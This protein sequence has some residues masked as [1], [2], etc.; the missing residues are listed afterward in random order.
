MRQNYGVVVVA[1]LVL[2]VVPVVV[3]GAPVVVVVEVE[4]AV[5]SGVAVVVLVVVVVEVSEE[6]PH[7]ANE[8]T[9][10]K[11]AAA[12]AMVW[13]FEVI[14]SDRLLLCLMRLFVV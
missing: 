8:A 3:A 1:V 6:P 5:A 12:R 11:L 9:S 14:K 7:A 2:V 10:A 4:V 13:N